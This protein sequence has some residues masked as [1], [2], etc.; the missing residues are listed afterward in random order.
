VLQLCFPASNIVG[1]R[2]YVLLKELT[3]GRS[4]KGA[5][6]KSLVA[7]FWTKVEDDFGGV[8]SEETDG[9]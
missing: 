2:Y 3:Q 8:A 9:G 5:T 4:Q 6:S 1:P 7:R